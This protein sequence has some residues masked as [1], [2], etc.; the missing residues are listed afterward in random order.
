MRVDRV[1]RQADQLAV[2]LL[3]LGLE[4]GEGAQLG[5]ADYLS[6]HNYISLA[7]AWLTKAANLV[8][9]L[10]TTNLLS[11]QSQACYRYRNEPSAANKR[12]A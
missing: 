7:S 2:A 3:E 5:G 6:E 9:N 1:G 10:F 11:T 12:S 4:L 8:C